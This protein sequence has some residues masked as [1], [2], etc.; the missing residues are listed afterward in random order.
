MSDIYCVPPPPPKEFALYSNMMRCDFSTTAIDV[1]FSNDS[2]AAAEEFYSSLRSI[3]GIRRT[4]LIFPSVGRTRLSVMAPTD[5]FNRTY[6]FATNTLT[7]AA[8]YDFKYLPCSCMIVS[9]L[10]LLYT[11]DANRPGR[12]VYYTSFPLSSQ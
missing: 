9:L 12:I 11:S 10:Y 4:S 8:G 3:H 7:D 5:S 6:R 2:S 1:L